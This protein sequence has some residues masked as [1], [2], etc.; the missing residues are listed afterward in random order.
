MLNF[1]KDF[2]ADIKGVGG[3]SWKDSGFR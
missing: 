2:K 3:W 1:L